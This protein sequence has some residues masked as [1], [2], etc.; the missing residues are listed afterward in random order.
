[1]KEARSWLPLLP[2]A[3]YSCC[4]NQPR[5]DENDQTP[6]SLRM[7]SQVSSKNANLVKE[8]T[9][10]LS[11]W[12]ELCATSAS[13]A[14]QW[15]TNV[16]RIVEINRNKWI[17]LEKALFIWFIEDSW[18]LTYLLQF[19]HRISWECSHHHDNI[20]LY[21]SPSA[22]FRNAEVEHFIGFSLP[23]LDASALTDRWAFFCF[24]HDRGLSVPRDRFM[25]N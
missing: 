21:W 18:I 8:E 6:E 16:S 9:R 2:S 3:S 11:S 12:K 1:M 5:V 7:L 22:L 25:E 23:S 19:V 17:I 10:P 24:C 15:L 14:T 13:A 20:A 4:A